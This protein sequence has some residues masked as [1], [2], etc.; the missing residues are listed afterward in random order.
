MP[1]YTKV[2]TAREVLP[3]WS[4]LVWARGRRIA[5]FNVDGTMYAMDDGCSHVGGPLS[6]GP[7]EGHVVTC[8]WH[9]AEFDV[10]TGKPLCPPAFRSV[11]CYAVRVTDGDIEIEV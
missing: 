5:L 3:G 4:R 10:R 6:D 8:P 1:D 11:G 2:A 7:L 9:G